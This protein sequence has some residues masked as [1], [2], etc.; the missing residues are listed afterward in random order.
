[1]VS[2]V[3]YFKTIKLANFVDID[4]SPL[5]LVLLHT[6]PSPCMFRSSHLPFNSGPS[7]PDSVRKQV[8]YL[9]SAAFNIALLHLYDI[10]PMIVRDRGLHCF[11]CCCFGSES[12]STFSLSSHIIFFNLSYIFYL[13][14]IPSCAV[15]YSFL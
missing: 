9:K 13:I 1:M 11:C 5:L 7:D 6:L 10:P 14:I 4:S 2:T 12:F 8:Y 15:F 3:P